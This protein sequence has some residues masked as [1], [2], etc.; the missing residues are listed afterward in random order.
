MPPRPFKIVSV[1]VRRSNERTH[2]ILE[3]NLSD[4]IMIQEPWYSRVGTSRLDVSAE[5]NP[6]KGFVSH[7]AWNVVSPHTPTTNPE[8]HPKVVTYVRKDIGNEMTVINELSHPAANT[9]CQVLHI[10]VGHKHLRLVNFYH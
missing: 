1:N 6:T 10:T 3:S 2:A 9:H 5:G 8:D 7:N 4:I